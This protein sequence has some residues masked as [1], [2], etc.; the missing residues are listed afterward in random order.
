MS[1][2]SCPDVDFKFPVPHLQKH[3]LRCILPS[4]HLLLDMISPDTIYY[5]DTGD[6]VV[7]VEKTLFRVRFQ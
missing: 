1:H 3:I 2:T 6:F 4:S 7:L 5:K